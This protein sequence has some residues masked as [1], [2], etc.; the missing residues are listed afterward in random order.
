MIRIRS[1]LPLV[2]LIGVLS[3]TACTPSEEGPKAASSADDANYVTSYPSE[4]SQSV[5]RSETTEAD[6]TRVSN[7][8]ESYPE[9][10][11]DEEAAIALEVAESADEAG[12]SSAYDS[13]ARKGEAVRSFITEEKEGLSRGLGGSVRYAMKDKGASEAA[14]T[15]GA[16]AASYGLPKAIDKQLEER[17]E[18][19]NS[20]HSILE[21]HEE[22]L[23]KESFAALKIQ[24]NEIAAASHALHIVL[25]EEKKRLEALVADGDTAKST[26]EESIKKENAVEADETSSKKRK[27]LAKKRVAAAES[28]L[29]T[30]DADTAS[31]KK[32]L[33][34]VEERQKALQ[35]AYDKAFK[36]FKKKLN[37][38]KDAADAAEAA[39]KGD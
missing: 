15:A 18:K 14:I 20:A 32:S 36:A 21:E 16:S 5:N 31:A 3:S 33:E 34:G 1:V 28:A 9:K 7:D 6:V 10:V 13:E 22:E 39:K 37:E 23:D 2:S 19:A 35:S 27:E 30:I 25:P 26:L 8:M 12:R 38:K 4:V 11:K 24:A 29:S 17:S